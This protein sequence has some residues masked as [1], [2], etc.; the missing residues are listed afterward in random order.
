MQNH[1]ACPSTK[2]N[3]C[4][5]VSASV[6]IYL[7]AFPN[8]EERNADLIRGRVS[9]S[10]SSTEAMA[11][12]N[13]S[14]MTEELLAFQESL[15]VAIANNELQEAIRQE[16][17]RKEDDDI[18][19]T[20]VIITDTVNNVDVGASTGSNSGITDGAKATGDSGI[21]DDTFD[22]SSATIDVSLGDR[23]TLAP[24]IEAVKES[25]GIRNITLAT[26]GVTGTALMSVLLV[27]FIAFGKRGGR[28]S[29][30]RGEEVLV[31]VKEKIKRHHSNRHSKSKRYGRDNDYDESGH[32]LLGS[33]YIPTNVSHSVDEEEGF[34]GR[35]VRTVAS[36]STHTT[37]S[38]ERLERHVVA[39]SSFANDVTTGSG[40]KDSSRHSFEKNTADFNDL[41]KTDCV[42]GDDLTSFKNDGLDFVGANTNAYIG[43]PDVDEDDNENDFVLGEDDDSEG[44]VGQHLMSV[45]RSSDFCPDPSESPQTSDSPD[46][47]SPQQTVQETVNSGT[48]L[49]Y[50]LENSR[51]DIQKPSEVP[52]LNSPP[53]ESIPLGELDTAIANSDW[54]AV[55]ATAAV[56]A[57]QPQPPIVRRNKLECS[58]SSANLPDFSEKAEELD[59]LIEAGDWKAVVTTAAIYDA[60]GESFTESAVEEDANR[61]CQSRTSTQG[62]DANDSCT[63]LMDNSLEGR[64]TG[65]SVTT[66]ASRKELVQEIH[67]QV[68]RLVRDVVPDEEKNIDEMML[69]FKD[70][71]EELL[72]TLRSMKEKVVAKKARLESRKIA[73]RNSR[74]R[75]ET[76]EFESAH[77]TGQSPNQRKIE[78]YESSGTEQ[79]RN[80]DT[81]TED[82]HTNQSYSTTNKGRCF[83][84]ARRI[85]HDKAAADA[86]S[87]AIQ[88]SLNELMEKEEI[89]PPSDEH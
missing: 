44:S 16:Y 21:F 65:R 86:A 3:N 50:S 78:T 28:A 87:W 74:I 76:E 23:T 11:Q 10:N 42:S 47:I 12:V 67:A 31:E 88:Q 5:D 77:R 18:N 34:T 32:E 36:D 40:S 57:S 43:N 45:S 24:S 49:P 22:S 30:R 25:N 53:E 66:S 33:T 56:F 52:S 59:R 79:Q 84:N 70:R 89:G 85:D 29:D 75:D 73:K 46:D 4:Q 60:K 54:A 6:G 61:S 20:V 2:F 38:H 82:L 51:S 7:S 26:I 9:S 14:A 48:K 13:P 63:S 37:S 81:D 64:S 27:L 62:S 1:L 80:L 35:T 58:C 39:S 19:P 68:I 71:E 41:T 55:G 17:R 83:E 8:V 69:Q 15:K 72:E